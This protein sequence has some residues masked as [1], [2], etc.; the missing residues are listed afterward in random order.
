MVRL[1][2]LLQ[3]VVGYILT[4]VLGIGL[5]TYHKY[6]KSIESTI[7]LDA[8]G[9]PVELEDFD[10]D[11]VGTYVE[12]NQTDLGNASILRAESEAV[13]MPFSNMV[14]FAK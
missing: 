12:L 6:R 14:Y 10:G 2:L 13:S 5:F 11:D 4:L 3:K 8:H 9:N 7:P 1:D